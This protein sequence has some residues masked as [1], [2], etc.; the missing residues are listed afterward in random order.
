[1][2]RT[3]NSDA[4]DRFRW[5]LSIISPTGA[6]FKR[7]GFTSCTSPGVTINYK[8]YIEGGSHM[9]PRQIHENAE[10]TPITLSRGVI[11][12]KG[13][14]DF[15]IWISDAYQALNPDP[16]DIKSDKMRNYRRTLV[17]EHLDRDGDTIK[18]YT[19]FNCVPT[20]YS[21]SSNFDAM[22]ESGLSIESLTFIYE[23]FEEE[24]EG[25]NTS[26]IESF[27]GLF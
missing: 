16:G 3:S 6:T 25:D 8:S 12:T 24:T 15:A 7:A 23:G 4:L 10:F 17:L 14:D 21:P 20:A 9:V 1:M 19:L 5:K 11:S 26:I 18:K 22:D 13:V 2:S 27:R